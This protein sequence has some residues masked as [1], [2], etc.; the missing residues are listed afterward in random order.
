MQARPMIQQYPS[1]HQVLQLFLL[2]D[3]IKHPLNILPKPMMISTNSFT[4]Y[5]CFGIIHPL[6]TV[7]WFHITRVLRCFIISWIWSI[8][9]QNRQHPLSIYNALSVT[10]VSGSCIKYLL[11]VAYHMMEAISYTAS[12]KA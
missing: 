4:S 10:N 1:I 5:A 11:A 7:T 6:T 9:S 3:Q 8:Q 12:F 2:Q